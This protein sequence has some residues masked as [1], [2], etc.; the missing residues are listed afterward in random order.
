LDL[1][2]GLNIDEV[3]KEAY[4]ELGENGLIRAAD[5]HSCSECTQEYKATSD[6][7]NGAD[8]AAVVG[9][10]ENR[11][12]PPLQNPNCETGS[13]NIAHQ[14]RIE[15]DHVGIDPAPVKMVVLDGIVMGPQH[16][17]F[18]NCTASLA[19]S[20]GGVF[21]SVHQTEYGVKCR[22]RD[23]ESSK[24]SGTQACHQ[25]REEWSKHQFNHAPAVISGLRRILWQNAG[26]Q[27][28]HPR[29]E[30]VTQPHD[31]PE[32]E[33][34]LPK[35]YFSAAKFY[36][37][38]TIC[39]PC[40][41]VIAWTKFDKSESPT[42]ILNFLESVFP[43]EESRPDYICID[44]ACKVL[45]TAISNG[46]WDR[47]WKKTTRFIVDSYHYINHHKNDYL[48]QVWCNPA[49]LNGSA[50]NLVISATDNTGRVFYKRAFNTQVRII[51]NEIPAF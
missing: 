38:E 5:Q 35:N 17:A 39:A 31:E 21:C 30:R 27:P 25:H 1:I 32:P 48:C 26:N 2:D 41:V 44:K 11:T 33:V 15:V 12:V 14:E 3:T 13:P 40:G 16:C 7:I 36:C 4:N 49:P 9:V 6:I 34:V 8:S 29:T 43:T 50:P 22:V 28:W 51:S 19:N 20:C 37:V 23:C 24:I 10:D 18:D 45:C 42:H 46:S 47:I